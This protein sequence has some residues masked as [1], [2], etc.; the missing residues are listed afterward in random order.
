MKSA[1]DIHGVTTPWRLFE[2]YQPLEG[3]LRRDGGGAGRA[4]SAL[5]GVR[6][7]ARSARASTSSRRDGRVRRRTHSR[8]R[9]HLQHLRRSAGL[10]R[11]WEL[12]MVPLLISPA[13]WARLET[14]PDSADDAAQSDP[15]RPVRPADPARTPG[16][17]RRRSCSRTRRSCGRATAFASR[18]AF[19]STCMRWT[20]RARPTVNGGCLP[21]ARRRR[22]APAMRSKTASCCSRSLPEAF[23]DCQVQRLAS[24]FRAQRDTLDDAGAAAARPA[25]GR[26]ADARTVQRNVLRARLPR[27]VSRLHAGRRRRPDGARPSR[28]HQDARRPR[29]RRRHLSPARRQLLRSAR[30]AQRFVA[31]RGGP[32]RGGAG[33][34]RDDRQRPRLG[35]DRDGRHHAVPAGV[36]PA[37][38]G[39]GADASVGRRPG[40]ADS[41]RS[42]STCSSTSTSWSSSGRSRRRSARA[43]LRPQADRREK[44]SAGCGDA[45][46]PGS[47][48]SAQDQVPLSTAP[49]WHR[50]KDWSRGPSCSGR[51]WRRRATPMR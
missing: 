6:A 14:A 37:P 44:I 51:T 46:A 9:R 36:V 25:E 2:G 47:T 26:A 12:D 32:G 19:T 28:L 42:C 33:R 11:P 43:D 50:H 27:A 3:T 4:A 22:R 41:P 48:S 49:V 24:F 16:C 20:W 35:R 7:V 15:G 31:R 1:T 5:R 45:R 29:T 17:C 40:G 13:E 39:R 8:E 38:A 30:A 23:R 34:Q 18:M 10:D 21:T